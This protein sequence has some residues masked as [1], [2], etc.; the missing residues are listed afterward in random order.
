MNTLSIDFSGLY[1]PH[2]VAFERYKDLLIKWNRKFNLTSLDRPDDI[3]ELHFLDSIA[4]S[5]V[6][7]TDIV[8]RETISILDIGAG[9]GFPGIPLKIIRPDLRM[10]LVDSVKKKCDF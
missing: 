10:T 8:S 1:Q 4:A 9:A 2:K 3:Y 7:P 6:L 5:A